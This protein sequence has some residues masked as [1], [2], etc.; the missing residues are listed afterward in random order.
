[1]ARSILP[2]AEGKFTEFQLDSVQLH[3]TA[4][5]DVLFHGESFNHS[6]LTLRRLPV[7]RGEELLLAAVHLVSKRDFGIVSQ[8]EEARRIAQRIRFAEKYIVK[9]TRTVIVGDF[10]MD[11][12]EEGMVLPDTFHSI[13]QNQL[14]SQEEDRT[15]QFVKYPYSINMMWPLWSDSAN[16]ASGTYAYPSK[17]HIR[18]QWQML[19]QVLVRVKA[20]PYWQ[21]KS[22]RVLT[23]A[24]SRSLVSNEHSVGGSKPDAINFSD[25]LPFVFDLKGN[26]EL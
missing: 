12:T 26:I 17:E 13:R 19:D 14:T 10:N 8:R 23:K 11:L 22:L 2:N 3:Q 6:R 15:L 7:G 24:G 4:M 1:M 21:H 20:L 9:H 5:S 16:R 18:S 25:H